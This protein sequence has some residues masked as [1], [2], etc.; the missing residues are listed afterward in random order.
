M[1]QEH[2]ETGLDIYKYR[3]RQARDDIMLRSSATKHLW[4][5]E[6]SNT[7][8][9]EKQQTTYAMLQETPTEFDDSKLRTTL[10]IYS[11]PAWKVF[12][13]TALFTSYILDTCLYS[14]YNPNKR[15]LWGL[16]I[17]FFL[18]FIFIFNVVVIV[19]LKFSRKWRKILNLVEPD[20]FKVILDIFLAL[21]YSF[22]YLIHLELSF[23]FHAISP[24]V[25]AMRVYMI[26]E[27]FYN[28]SSQAGSNQWTTFLFQYI[29]L[30]LLS[31]HTW[32]CVW[33]LFSDR[34]F[35]LHK[36]RSS[37]SHVAIYLPTEST[38]DWYYVCAYWSVMFLTTNAL[39]DLFPVTTI[40]RVTGI[41]AILIGFL[42]TT[43]VFVGS[44]TSQFITVTTRRAKY[45]R[46][47][48]KIKN[49]LKLIKMDSET[50]KRIIR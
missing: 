25:A 48:R 46:R 4:D 29:I 16:V 9:E 30:F 44:L 19:G 8:T 33:Y 15:P 50:T 45:V 32:S 42:L 36:I 34:S 35:D 17:L 18:N 38:I 1:E 28:R 37:W 40:E 11:N 43:V 7:F 6:A 41:L 12:I 3:G 5:I 26:V 22:L 21:P 20:T 31:V 47:L 24:V 39:G 27:Y 14:F 2:S 13:M 23:D 49:H 10:L